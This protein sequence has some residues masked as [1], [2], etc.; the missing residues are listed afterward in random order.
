MWPGENTW[1]CDDVGSYYCLDWG[2]VS[3]ATW[4]RAK[5]TALLR[6][7]IAAPDCI[8]GTSNPVNFSVLKSSNWKQG[9]VTSIRIDGKELDPG[10]LMYLKLVTDNHENSSYQPFNSF[11]EEIENFQ[12]LP[13]SKTCSSHCLSL[14]LRHKLLVCGG[15]QHGRPLALGSKGGEPTRAF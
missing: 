11:C 15:D 8:H 9:H 14:Y 7:G 5:H 1:P 3:W 10:T 2:C 6:K 4:P 12:S 13:R